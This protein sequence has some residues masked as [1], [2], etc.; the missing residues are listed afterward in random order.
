MP[1]A[2]PV[3]PS[4]AEIVAQLDR[5]VFGQEEAKRVLARAAYKHYV[6]LAASDGERPAPAFGPQHV[7]LVGPTGSGKS[8]LIRELARALDVP[9]AFTP[10]TRLVETGY[11]GEQVESAVRALIAAAGGDLARASRGIVVL[12][13]VDKI[14]AIDMGTRDV[15]GRGVQNSLLALLDGVRVPVAREDQNRTVDTSSMLFLATGA[16][17]ELDAIAMRRSGK[18]ARLGFGSE[19]GEDG[20]TPDA[21]A[22]YTTED[23]VSFGLIP[24]FIGRFRHVCHLDALSV[25]E[26]ARLA[27]EVEDS[28]LRRTQD[29]LARH[30]V[31]LE[32]TK[33]ALREIARR[34][35]KLDTGARALDRVIAEALAPLEWQA[36]GGSLRG[37][38]VVVDLER[39][40]AGGRWREHPLR[41]E[42]DGDVL[43][44][45]RRAR[46]LMPVKPP[47]PS[48][49][50][51]TKGWPRARLEQRLAELR[52]A[53]EIERATLQ[54]RIF[55]SNFERENV[56]RLDAVVRLAEE[57]AMRRCTLNEFFEAFKSAG[58]THMQAS[59]CYLDYLRF[60]Q[61]GG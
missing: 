30:G 29:C 25:D 27:T 42:A 52:P 46:Q 40:L 36:L 55:W 47:T 56:A 41:G 43:E 59:L 6:G 35:L 18:V 44:L 23:F 60:K 26:L 22:D 24:E 32:V 13:E 19:A 50:S 51:D 31:Q 54:A 39:L 7:L 21:R 57:L 11:V 15:S 17:V 5:R 33:G 45:R 12:D 3:F 37:R 20:A 49:I 34:A 28:A 61:Q 10:A 4:P 9:V 16:F 8:H 53:L 14:R 58:T 1:A 48:Q 2:I 38:R